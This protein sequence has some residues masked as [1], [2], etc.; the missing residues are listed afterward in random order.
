MQETAL[1]LNPMRLHCWLVL[2]LKFC[3][4]CV[5]CSLLTPRRDREQ[6]TQLLFEV[7]NCDG[8]YFQDQA[9]LSLYATGK[10][11]GC[12][13]DV[14]HGKV[15]IATVT[16]GQVCEG[17]LGMRRGHACM[18]AATFQSAHAPAIQ[19][20]R[21]DA[22]TISKAIK[23]CQNQNV[24]NLSTGSLLSSLEPNTPNPEL[25]LRYGLQSR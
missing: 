23:L 17:N 3:L 25:L 13:V 4:P 18:R 20:A 11:T 2:S 10:L 5:P 7:F 16:D 24:S 12:V 19:S 22:C 15:D 21:T 6:L 14:G 9:T 8:L 1:S